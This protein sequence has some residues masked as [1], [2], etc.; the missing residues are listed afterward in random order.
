M[1]KPLDI[2]VGRKGN[3]EVQELEKVPP[4]FTVTSE[5]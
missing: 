4:G 1:L 5:A 3:V 2:L